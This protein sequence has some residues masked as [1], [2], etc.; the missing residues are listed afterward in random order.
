M[1]ADREAVEKEMRL[2]CERSDHAGAAALGLREY[3]PEI[4]GF[5]VAFMRRDDDASEVFSIFTERMWRGLP[6]FEWAS[7]F[8]T[9]AYTIARNAARTYDAVERRRA[10]KESPLPEG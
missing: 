9:W 1:A 8:R 6:Q 10:R 7:S 5:L 2:L 3:G 4:Y